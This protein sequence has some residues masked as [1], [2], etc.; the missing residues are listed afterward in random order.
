VSEVEAELEELMTRPDGPFVAKLPREPGRRE[1][2]Y[3]HLFS[4][5]APP[6]AAGDAGA[7]N[8]PANVAAGSLAGRVAALEAEVTR[9]RHEI[10]ALKNRS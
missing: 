4:G 7:A 6:P 8:S 1:S 3:M 10:D 9:L 2:R 5:E